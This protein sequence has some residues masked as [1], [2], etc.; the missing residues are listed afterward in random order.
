MAAQPGGWADR[1]GPA[2]AVAAEE[3]AVAAAV[4]EAEGVRERCTNG[5]GRRRSFEQYP[6]DQFVPN[7]T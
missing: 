6:Y 3:A 7:T 4:V 1:T 5:R 2:E